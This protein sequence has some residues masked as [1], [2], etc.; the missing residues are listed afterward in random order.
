MSNVEC[1]R[2]DSLD[3]WVAIKS[4]IFEEP[5]VFKL[6]FIVQWNVIECKFAVTCHNRTL[7]R[8]RR[9]EK[10]SLTGEHQSSWAGLFSVSDLKHI[11]QQL[12]CV[13]DVLAPCF[14]D[15]SEFEDGSVWD[16]LFPS[17]KYGSDDERRV[18]DAPC[19]TLETYFS[20]AIDFCGRTIVLDTL[21]YQDER[22]ADDYFEN[23]QEFKRKS[24]HDEM[25]RAKG[26]L[27]QVESLCI[28]LRLSALFTIFIDWAI[29]TLHALVR[30]V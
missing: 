3:G 15:L 8:R 25:S 26:H 17:R 21:F 24:M 23:L 22:D 18:S 10:F 28:P 6:G 12:I 29:V 19:R 5:E 1:E 11:H 7:Q 9:K 14:P 30:G 16:L 27:R 4:N 2:P 20:T 13:S